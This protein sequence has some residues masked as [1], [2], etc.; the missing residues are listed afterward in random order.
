MN[1]RT[2]PFG[3][4]H[5]DRYITAHTAPEPPRQPRVLLAVIVGICISTAAIYALRASV[6][7]HQAMPTASPEIEAAYQRGLK[8]GM[9]RPPTYNPIDWTCR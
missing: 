8:A 6:P 2:E 3:L 9:Q 7:T 4:N 5:Q 1:P